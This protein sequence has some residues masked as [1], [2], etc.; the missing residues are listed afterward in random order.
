MPQKTIPAGAPIKPFAEYQIPILPACSLRFHHDE[1]IKTKPG[2]TQDS[3]TPRKKRATASVAKVFADAEA[4]NVAP[5]R[6]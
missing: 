2:L 1:V 6:D 5:I 3:K 4:A